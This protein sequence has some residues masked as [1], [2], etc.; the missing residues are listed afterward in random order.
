MHHRCHGVSQ[1]PSS[2]PSMRFYWWRHPDPPLDQR[3]DRSPCTCVCVDRQ[4][5]IAPAASSAADSPRTYDRSPGAA[6]PV[7][8]RG[9]P[10]RQHRCALSDRRPRDR[11]RAAPRRGPHSA[12]ASLR[13]T[14]WRAG[15]QRRP[16]PG[17]RGAGELVTFV[18]HA[19]KESRQPFYS[20]SSKTVVLRPSGAE[21]NRPMRDRIG[22]ADTR[23]LVASALSGRCGVLRSRRAASHRA[24]AP[25]HGHV[26]DAQ[27][28]VAGVVELLRAGR[29]SAA[30]AAAAPRLGRRQGAGARLRHRR[31]GARTRHGRHACIHAC[32]APDIIRWSCY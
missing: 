6:D 28:G 10:G 1:E 9:R 21:R 30:G 29:V 20:D 27:R 26:K 25:I 24:S 5:E 14:G 11:G 23:H 16:E 19:P 4:T 22:Q 3:G 17:A 31:P 15:S 32:L 8:G 18:I 13:T 7:A 2:T 12:A